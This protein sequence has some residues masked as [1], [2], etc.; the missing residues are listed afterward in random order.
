MSYA[1]GRRF[2]SSLVANI[3]RSGTS[4]LTGLLLARWMGPE[5]YG[6]MAF[7]LAS[8]MAFRQ[9][10]DMASSSAFF[11]FLSQRPRSRRFVTFFWRWV[12]LQFLIS[13]L[14][15][16]LLLPDNWIGGI[17]KGEERGLVLLAFVA[18][19]MQGM[20]WPIASQMAEA[21]RET[22][23]VQRISTLV[24]LIYFGVV[25]SLW[26]AGR[27]AIPL[28]FAAL[29]FEWGLAGWLSARLYRGQAEL[30]ES[31]VD[32]TDTVATVWTEFWRYCLPLVPYAWLGFA[33]DFADR[34]MLQHWGGAAEQA[35][36]AVA[37]QFAAVVLLATASILQIFWK[38]IAEAHHRHDDARI[39]WLYLKASRSLYFAGAV[40]AGG[41]LPWAREILQLTLGAAYAGGAVPLMLM[42]LYPV[43]QSMG[44]I[45]GT[46]LYATGHTRIQMALG[47]AIMVSSLV[48]AYFMLAPADASVPGLAL[49]AE[50]LAFKMVIMQLMSVNI[51][52]WFISRAFGWKYD[53]RY[54][55]VG[56]ALAVGAGWF[57][58]A[59]VT[60]FAGAPVLVMMAATV[61]IY[62]ALVAG[63][64]YLM[65]WVAGTER[66]EL[67]AIT[68]TLVGG[69]IGMN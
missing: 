23:R 10:L 66:E 32:R 46:M 38:E 4:F 54:Q 47:L 25:L 49:A 68:R 69:K 29:T 58:K 36:Y 67:R 52:A 20:V 50:G 31:G 13:L 5:D 53:W 18:A 6:R 22:I 30:T 12:G 15:V 14:V 62:L 17:W 56:L 27:L 59:L 24:V 51:M 57:V 39:E 1:I 43:H 42:F 26:W 16:G 37:Y 64:L 34:W 44:Q 48:V 2:A 8:F 33:H 7:L 60:G 3:L 28:L 19:F 11:T 40:V 41:V 45:G 35:Y 21:Q 9:L 55:I 63:A 61:P 65:P